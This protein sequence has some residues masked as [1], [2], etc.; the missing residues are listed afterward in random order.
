MNCFFV[1][2]FLA[3]FDKDWRTFV[4]KNNKEF[5]IY[6]CIFILYLYCLYIIYY[7]FIIQTDGNHVQMF[8]LS[9]LLR[10]S[11]SVG[12]SFYQINQIVLLLKYTA[13]TSFNFREELGKVIPYL[14]IF[15][16]FV[17]GIS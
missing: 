6:T 13:L 17:S 15:I 11:Y 14:P 4:S 8:K 2:S 7:I 1:I 9:G 5:F 16:H 3:A 12:K 10:L